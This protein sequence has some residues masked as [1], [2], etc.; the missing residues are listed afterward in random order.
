[1][2]AARWPHGARAACAFTF[3]LDAESLWLARG[4]TEPVALSQ[5]RIAAHTRTELA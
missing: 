1:M 2:I 3:D 4:V 5:G